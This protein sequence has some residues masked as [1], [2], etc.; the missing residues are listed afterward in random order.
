MSDYE[1]LLSFNKRAVSHEMI[2]FLASTTA[3]IIQVKP[4]SEPKTNTAHIIPTLS[5]F[6][7][8]LI[9][10]SNVQTPTLM[11]T[12]VYLS[13]LK[14]IIPCNVYGIE[15]T[16]HRIFLGCLIL[17]AKT[18]NDSSPMNKHWAQYTDGL[19]QIR[20][21]NTIERE[22][23][24]YFD[25]DVTIKTKD[26]IIC[27][28]PLLQPI[29]E[30]SLRKN[31]MDLLLFNAPTPG[32][33]RN[34]IDSSSPNSHSRSSSNMSLPSLVSSATLSTVES[35]RSR[36]SNLCGN[37]HINTISEQEEY[38]PVPRKTSA[39]YRGNPYNSPLSD[40]ENKAQVP[41]K[42]RKNS[43]G[44]PTILKSGLDKPINQSDTKR[45]AWVSFFK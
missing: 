33:V 25:W 17:A 37:T 35:T 44:Y 6:I 8:A 16:R 4:H 15:T 3:S 13:K 21:V 42:L 28:S 12:T 10:H 31:Q 7:K 5:N 36:L 40:T 1:A 39:A 24:E 9:K 20:E 30:Q 18:L 29:I 34:Y 2:Q 45:S 22:L 11:A 41:T 26:L 43:K 38:S 27:L 14:S 19:L 32:K 23:L